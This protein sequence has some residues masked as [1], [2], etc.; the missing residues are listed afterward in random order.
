MPHSTPRRQARQIETLRTQFAQTE[1][2]PFADLLTPERLEQALREEKALWREAVWTP[3]L[4]LW[5]FLRQVISPDGSCR[6]TVN[7]VL[8]WLVAR[9]EQPCSPQTDPYCKARQRLPESLLQRLMGETGKAL[10]Q[11][12]PGAWRWKKRR[13]KIVDGTT[14]SMPDTPANQAAYPQPNAQPPGLGFPVARLVVVFCLACG[15]VLDAA[16]GR[17]A[18]KQQGE[19]SLLRARADALEP[20]DVLLADRYYSGWFDLAWWWQRGVDVVT[21]LHQR[22]RCDLRRGQRLGK[23]DHRVVWTKPS[24]PDWMDE[25]TYQRLP[26]ALAVREVRVRVPQRGFRTKVLVVVTTLL[27]AQAYLTTDLAVIYRLRWQAELDLRSLKVALHLDVLR[28]KSPA[29]VRKE[30]WTHL[31]AYNLIRGVM[32]QSAVIHDCDPR[33]LSFKGALQ[34]LTTFAE[35]LLEAEAEQCEALYDWLLVTIGANQ[36]GDRPDRVEPRA[37][38]RRPKEYPLL[39]KPR[40]EARKKLQQKR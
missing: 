9:R 18:G 34:A 15:T 31:L 33:E 14:V 37:R 24:R 20:G 4:T 38:K 36:V 22:R 21:R 6:F 28:C 3:V 1:G 35:R 13:V 12:S 27:D 26:A 40:E 16:L 23:N 39:T 29:M 8:A 30:V 32:A 2:L 7:R 17:Y 10:H 19:N 25:A 5:A 11:R